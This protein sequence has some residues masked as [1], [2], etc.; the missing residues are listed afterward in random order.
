MSIHL[1]FISVLCFKWQAGSGDKEE[2]LYYYY[3]HLVCVV[4]Y[5]K[6]GLL[7]WDFREAEELKEKADSIVLPEE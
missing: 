3:T 7:E 1:R 5:W 4:G 6:S 2:H